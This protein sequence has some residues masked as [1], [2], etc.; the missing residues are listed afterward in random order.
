MGYRIV[1]D[2][3]YKWR[4]SQENQRNEGFVEE[5]EEEKNSH[6]ETREIS[7]WYFEVEVG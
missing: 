2:Y 6:V 5:F 3:Y 7:E 4:G 1:N